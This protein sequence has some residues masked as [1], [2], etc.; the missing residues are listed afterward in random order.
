MASRGKRK[1]I[2]E[3][4]PIAAAPVAATQSFSTPI[5]VTMVVGLV[6]ILLCLCLPISGFYVE[7]DLSGGSSDTQVEPQTLECTL[8]AFV[9][10]FA[11]LGAFTDWQTFYGQQL[12]GGVLG[13]SISLPDG[14]LTP[15]QQ[16]M[17]QQGSWTIYGTLVAIIFS[18]LVCVIVFLIARLRFHNMLACL[19]ASALLAIASTACLIVLIAAGL[20]STP[21]A[22]LSAEIGIWFVLLIAWAMFGTLLYFTLRQRKAKQE[23]RA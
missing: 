7:F 5:H 10:L 9:F 14:F 12:T 18:W 3:P 1:R 8:P 17:I 20:Q 21:Q 11:P 22:G 15:S 16:S 23:D 6:L 2:S 13:G 4:A 19:I